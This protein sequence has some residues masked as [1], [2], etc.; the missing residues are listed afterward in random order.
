MLDIS[1]WTYQSQIEPRLSIPAQGM[2]DG[3][4][5]GTTPIQGLLSI[6][7]N[8][9]FVLFYIVFREKTDNMCDMMVMGGQWNAG[10]TCLKADGILGP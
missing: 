2:T 9:A 1:A 4:L 8:Q 7:F 10:V 5:R 3:R 6:C